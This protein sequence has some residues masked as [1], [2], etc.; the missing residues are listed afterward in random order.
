[1]ETQ[2]LLCGELEPVGFEDLRADV[3]VQA[4]E[5]DAGVAR[6]R[7]HGFFGCRQTGLAGGVLRHGEAEFLVL[8]GG[9]DELMRV[10]VDAGSQPE[11]D[12]GQC[13]A[14][15]GDLR[16]ALQFIEAV[17]HNPAQFHVQSAV[18]LGVGLV[19]AVQAQV[20][21]PDAGPGCH[22]ELAARAG[23]QPES[24]VRHPGGDSGA[25]ERL[26]GVVD[27]HSPADVGERGIKSVLE[28]PGTGPEIGLAHNKQRRTELCLELADGDAVNGEFAGVVLPDILRPHGLVE[29][30]QVRGNREP[31]RGQR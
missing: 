7:C 12:L 28:G 15:G 1:M 8:M 22:S 9:G 25:Q 17:H 20:F 19:V 26:A 10:R 6:G 31:F 21:A 18:D 30:V 24:F 14:S 11:H 5:F 23:V 2:E 29:R 16:D 3:A 27:V 13:A 4:Q